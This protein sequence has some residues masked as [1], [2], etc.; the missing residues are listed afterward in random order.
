MK[1]KILILHASGIN[2]DREAAWA[3]ELAGGTP[4]IVHINAL[5]GAAASYHLADYQMLIIGGGFSYGD[6]LGAGKRLGL[7]LNLD[8]RDEL[9]LFVEK[10]KPILGICN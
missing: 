10:G 2:R 9:A 1:P 8:L 4:E 7:D 3:C 5:R 6:A